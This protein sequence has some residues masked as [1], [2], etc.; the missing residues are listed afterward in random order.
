MKLSFTLLFTGLLP[1]SNLVAS[2]ATWNLNPT[3]G[4]W[5]TA[6]NWTPATVPNGPSDTA[7]FDVSSTSA[8]SVS[9]DTEVSSIVFNPGASAFT[10]TV[11]TNSFIASLTLSGAGIV[12]NSAVTQNFVTTA[13]TPRGMINFTGNASA[14]SGTVFTNEGKSSAGGAISFEDTSTAGDATIINQG[15]GS[16]LQ[17]K[18]PGFTSFF[19]NATAGNS[20]ISCQGGIVG[21]FGGTVA[22]AGNSTAGNA[23]ITCDGPAATGGL[24]GSIALDEMST[25]GDAVITLNGTDQLTSFR[26]TADLT[27][28]SSMGNAT[29]I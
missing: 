10:I 22:F 19:D 3:S 23:T 29:F 26:A 13:L 27:Q 24:G 9:A 18:E 4:D 16:D 17:H 28:N 5:N 2:S 6:T 14:G 15:G 12:N 1:F 21:G 7:I 25:A 20:T 8:V 11:T